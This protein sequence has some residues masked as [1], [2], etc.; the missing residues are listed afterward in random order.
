[1]KAFDLA[2]MEN[3]PAREL[4]ELREEIRQE[5]RILADATVGKSV[6]TEQLERLQALHDKL[7]SID[8]IYQARNDAEARKPIRPPFPGGDGGGFSSSSSFSSSGKSLGDIFVDSPGWRTQTGNRPNFAVNFGEGS[9]QQFLQKATMT[10]AVTAPDLVRLSP[11]VLQPTQ[12]PNVLDFVPIEDIR[13]GSISYLRE[14]SYTNAANVVNEGVEKPEASLALESVDVHPRMIAVHQGVTRQT[15]QDVSQARE[16]VNSRLSFMVRAKAEE[17]IIQ[18]T[19]AVG[20]PQQ[21]TGYINTPNIG[22][23]SAAGTNNIEGIAIGINEVR[24]VGFTEPNLIIMHPDNFLTVQT[25]VT[26]EGIFLYNHPAQSGP[27]TLWGVPLVLTTGIP[28]NTAL[29][30]DFA[31]FSRI[32][33]VGGVQSE[34]GYKGSD[35]TENIIRFLVEMRLD[36]AVFRP[37]A[38]CLVTNLS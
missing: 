22:S 19:G 12:P 29:V 35:F 33:T 25:Y 23:E 1:M 34:V 38:F 4:A 30:G 7:T 27:R 24:T 8:K 5:A 9:V 20:P 15:L 28:V 17:Q 3:L 13:G 37:K 16:F 26:T 21:I 36:L 18:G 14:T 2:G 32:Y 10:T 11:L 6:T 31:N